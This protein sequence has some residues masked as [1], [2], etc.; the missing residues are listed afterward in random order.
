MVSAIAVRCRVFLTSEAGSYSFHK[1]AQR[2]VSTECI[3]PSYFGVLGFFFLEF[4]EICQSLPK[5]WMDGGELPN[6]SA[7]Y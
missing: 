4:N 2:A 5:R 7:L 3:T 6:F 1:C